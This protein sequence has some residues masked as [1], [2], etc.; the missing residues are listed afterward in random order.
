VISY[1][2]AIV[3]SSGQVAETF[4]IKDRGRIKEG[5]FA[6]I[7]IIDPKTIRD[8]ATFE[9]PEQ[10]ASGIDYVLVNGKVAID[11]G[12]YTGALAGQILKRD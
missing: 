5:Y 10:I 4:N 1:G 2:R 8:N 12:Q 6:D 11:N 3:A 9:K 7:V